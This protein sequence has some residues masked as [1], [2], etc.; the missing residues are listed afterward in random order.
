MTQLYLSGDWEEKNSFILPLRNG[1]AAMQLS[2]LLFEKKKTN[3]CTQWRIY[4]RG[5][6]G[7]ILVKKAEMTEGR[8]ASW[9]SK[10]EPAPLL[11]SKSGSATVLTSQEKCCNAFVQSQY[12]TFVE[13]GEKQV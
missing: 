7:L 13:F 1:Q 9:A 11:S 8:K 3:S 12:L 5:P 6:G 4:G 10:I 2:R